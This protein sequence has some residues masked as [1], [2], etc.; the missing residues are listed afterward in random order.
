ML[1]TVTSLVYNPSIVFVCV[2]NF[3]ILML[4]LT[5]CLSALT[6]V[7]QVNKIL[8]CQSKWKYFLRQDLPCAWLPRRQESPLSKDHFGLTKELFFIFYLTYRNIQSTSTLKEGHNCRNKLLYLGRSECLCF[9]AMDMVD[10]SQLGELNLKIISF[11][12]LFLR[13]KE[14]NDIWKCTG[15]SD[16]LVQVLKNFLLA[17]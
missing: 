15:K 9:V 4:F 14:S 6:G 1:S 8:H 2:T 3:L 7:Y 16:V 10:F 5:W 12:Y 17:T 11:K 13:D